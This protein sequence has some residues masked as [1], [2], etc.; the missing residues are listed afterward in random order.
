MCLSVTWHIGAVFSRDSVGVLA[1][2]S[3]RMVGRLWKAGSHVMFA[4]NEGV[5]Y[6]VRREFQRLLAI[7]FS[8][9]CEVCAFS[10]NYRSSWIIHMT[11]G[12][13][14]LIFGFQ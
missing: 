7:V 3:H 12:E 11:F 4:G 1:F 5:K 14:L 13:L 9:Y 2:F 8:M 6:P 10:D